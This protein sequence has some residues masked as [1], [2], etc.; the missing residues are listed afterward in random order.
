MKNFE[1][2]LLYDAVYNLCIEAN[3]RLPKEVYEKLTKYEHKNRPQII[4]NAY[5]ACQKCRPLCQDTGQVVIFLEMGQNLVL[6]GEYVEDVINQAVADCYREKFYR[7]SV[8][9]DA[10]F[11]RTNTQTNTPVVI[12]TRIIPGTGVKILLAI[13][14]GGAENCSQVKMFNPTVNREEIFKFVKKV[15]RDAGENACPPMSLG[16]GAGGTIEEACVLAKKALYTGE[17]V[18]TIEVED[19]FEIKVLTAPTHIASLPVCV[20]VN[21]HSARHSSCTIED[22]IILYEKNDYEMQSMPFI[23]NL[24]EV[25]TSDVERIKKLKHKEKILLT[26]TIYTARDNAHKKLVEILECGAILPIDLQDIILFYAGPCPTAPGEIIGPV[27]PT[28]SKRMDAFAPTLFE[29]GVLAV[30]GKGDRGI[31][32]G[33]YLKLTG[34][35]ACL[36]QDCIQSAEVAFFEELGTE[37]IYK[38]EVEKLPLEVGE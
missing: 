24:E 1:I 17:E 6:E 3:V 37:A 38:L 14:G 13:K 2:K 7:K 36:V 32:D 31:R 28:T 12:H 8:V 20:N 9:S 15:A 10:I 29:Q 5:S 16:I 25:K 27:G 22:G 4:Q 33:V 11:D 35:V 18:T 21:C 34:G 19:V 26:G 30:I 23:Y